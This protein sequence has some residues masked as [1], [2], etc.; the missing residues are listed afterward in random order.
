MAYAGLYMCLSPQSKLLFE[1][2]HQFGSGNLKRYAVRTTVDL[3]AAAVTEQ[4]HTG[5]RMQ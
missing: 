4:I 2:Y 5:A 1:S 3:H